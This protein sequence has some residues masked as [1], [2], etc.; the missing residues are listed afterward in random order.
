MFIKK[1]IFLAVLLLVTNI[2]YAKCTEPKGKL[3]ADLQ[4]NDRLITAMKEYDACLKE[5]LANKYSESNINRYH[6]QQAEMQALDNS[7]R[8]THEKEEVLMN[9]LEDIEK[10]G[11]E[12]M[13]GTS[14]NTEQQK[15]YENYLA[16]REKQVEAAAKRLGLSKD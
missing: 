2:A 11:W 1:S 8:K 15:S 16:Q 7:V 5:E 4:A 6:E 3:G 13:A 12:G 10:Y 9:P 14:R